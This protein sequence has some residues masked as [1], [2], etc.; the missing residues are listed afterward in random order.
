MNDWTQFL[1]WLAPPLLG[2]LIGYVTNYVAIR[3]LF[4]PLR[5]WRVFGLRVPLTPG[6][7][8]AKRA[9]L[10]VRMGET[11]GSHLLTA[12][13]V[14]AVLGRDSFRRELRGAVAEKLG[15][16][17]DRELGPLESLVPEEF[18]GRFRELIDLLRW[19]LLN[20]IFAYLKSED[21]RRRLE[22]YLRDRGEELLA[23]DLQSCL[24]EDGYRTL[25]E[26][27]RQRIDQLLRDPGIEQAL[28]RFVE[29]RLDRLFS[30]EQ[31]LAELLPEDLVELLLQQLEKEVPG[32]LEKFGGL[33]YDPDFRQ[34]LV[35]KACEGI[36]TFLDSLQG[37]AG[38]LSGFINLDKIYD[39]LP[40]FLDRTGDEIARWLKEEKTQQQVAQMLR[41]RV[42][43]MLQRPVA[44]Y[45]ENLPYEKVAGVRRFAR[46]QAIGMLHSPK[47]A[48]ALGRLAENGLDRIKDRP[49]GELLEQNLPAGLL[50][51]W[52]RDLPQRLLKW[53]RS[54]AVH[55]AMDEI[56][57]RQS[58]EL[59]L[60]RPLG[61]LSARV[62]GDVREELIDGLCRQ[63][64]ELLQRE[65]PPL[66]ETLN[67]SRMV[68]E[69]VNR[70]DILQ[71]EGLLLSIMQ[72]QFKYINLF[73]G[74]L[75]FLIGLANLL[76]LQL[77]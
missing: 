9:E 70:L 63:L 33:L 15:S 49:F 53:L 16:F 11:V 64:G 31:S 23:R 55:R 18:R 7:I 36:D 60:Q 17:L 71:V 3:M 77:R 30:S 59:L 44:S 57:R 28:G 40:E 51:D 76:L 13:D 43:A 20:L 68:E 48:A 52:R 1:P 74:L 14:G 32:L 35:K 29:E 47:T 10:A 73:G 24:S 39:R 65:V 41:E 72:E 25:C 45:L 62:P 22:V 2:A 19:K 26:Q 27:L 21:C 12:D 8:P 54:P 46:E 50:D 69:K 38:L 67:I 5:P 6:I 42:A 37:L 4:R 34:R 75:G 61:R 66:V 56:L 58:E